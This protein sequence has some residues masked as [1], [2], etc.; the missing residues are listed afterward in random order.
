MISMEDCSKQLILL[1]ELSQSIKELWSGPYYFGF[2]TKFLL[3]FSC[4][5][6][7]INY[8]IG[9]IYFFIYCKQLGKQLKISSTASLSGLC[10][11][12]RSCLWYP[13]QFSAK[14]FVNLIKPMSIWTG[15]CLCIVIWHLQ[16]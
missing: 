1:C 7:P 8:I 9:C 12:D 15:A 13:I 5:C 4:I 16:W 2:L 14:N 10:K 3:N 6:P 11:E